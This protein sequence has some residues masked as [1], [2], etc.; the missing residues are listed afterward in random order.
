MTIPNEFGTGNAGLSAWWNHTIGVTANENM[1]LST[2]LEFW[3]NLTAGQKTAI[4]NLAVTSLDTAITE[5]TAIKTHIT[6]EV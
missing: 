3:G 1:K 5:L 4:K 6:N 2:F